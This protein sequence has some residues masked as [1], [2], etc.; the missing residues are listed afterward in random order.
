MEWFHVRPHAWNSRAYA[1]SVVR[2]AASDPCPAPACLTVGRQAP[3]RRLPGTR[4][5]DRTTR[6]YR[7]FAATPAVALHSQDG[8]ALGVNALVGFQIIHRATQS[9]RPGRDRAPFVSR[10]LRLS[11]LEVE[12]AHAVRKAAL[13]VRVNVAVIDCG[14]ADAGGQKWRD[15]QPPEVRASGRRDS[16]LLPI[17][18]LARLDSWIVNHAR[19]R[20]KTQIQQQRNKIASAGGQ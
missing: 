12:R 19:V 8:D 15:V 10:R 17:P 7:R 2:L 13:K 18:D 1:R 16:L 9:P 5:L 6:R 3:P 14:H 20:R 11:G 4:L